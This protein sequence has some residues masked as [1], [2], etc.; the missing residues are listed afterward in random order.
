MATPTINLGARGRSHAPV[1]GMSA[2]APASPAA[3][4]AEF[5][6]DPTL[7]A[8]GRHLLHRARGARGAARRA[9]VQVVAVLALLAV[10]LINVG[11]EWAMH[12]ATCACFIVAGFCLLDA[13]GWAVAG[14]A[15]LVT[16][17]MIKRE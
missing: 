16:Q 9:F 17:G 2:T 1:Y 8:R 6:H 11:R 14:G 4:V 7:P 5:L 12:V 13:L 10:T 3:R 15:L